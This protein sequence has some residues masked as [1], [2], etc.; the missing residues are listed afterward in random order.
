MVEKEQEEMLTLS[1][2][3]EGLRSGKLLGLRCASCGGVT[4]HPMPVCQWCG[5]RSLERTKL[6]GAGELTTFTVIRVPSEGFEGEVPYIPCLVKTEEGP[7]VVGRLDYDAERATQAAQELLGKRVRMSGA[8][9][10]KGDKFSG[11]AHSCPVFEVT[12]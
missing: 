9:T 1:E 7:C 5:G 12:E 6:S 8:Y 3:E 11:G 2:Y 4:C 10:Y